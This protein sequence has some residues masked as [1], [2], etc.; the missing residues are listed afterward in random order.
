MNE[1]KQKWTDAALVLEAL[2]RFHGFDFRGYNRDFVLERLQMY[3]D[4]V[5]CE[6]AIDLIPR[7]G[8]DAD[9]ARR[10]CESLT[11]RH[12]RMFRD[13]SSYRAIRD[14]VFPWLSTFPVFRIWHAGCASG[15]EVLSLAILLKEAGLY[16]RATVFATDISQ[17]TLKRAELAVHAA[18]DEH[19]L[20]AAYSEAGGKL[21]LSEYFTRRGEHLVFSRDLL[22]RVTFAEHN[23]AQDE[24]FSEVHL[25]IC[26]NV[27]IYFTEQL[28]RR[29]ERIF[30][31]SLCKGGYLWLGEAEAVTSEHAGVR[32]R[33]TDLHP[34]RVFRR[35]QTPPLESPPRHAPS[36]SVTRQ[37]S[38]STTKP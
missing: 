3:T 35:V 17:T 16:E 14:Q 15:E 38:V 1:A 33:T 30:A 20:I 11:V 31:E 29:A 34:M 9:F 36:P 6:R 27:F 13:P 25:V 2:H 24:V 28:Q 37:P 19:E 8:R 21:S 23:L 12:T 7:L 10:I 18:K 26:R 32:F 22:R 4:E 5:E